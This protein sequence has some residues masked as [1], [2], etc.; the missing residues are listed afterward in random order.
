MRKLLPIFIFVML[1]N[2]ITAQVFK[3]INVQTAGTL[4]TLL[5]AAEKT[6]VTNLTITG[7]IDASDFKFMQNNLTV[8]S[9]LDIS[10][11]TIAEYLGSD[12]PTT[13]FPTPPTY[14]VNEIPNSPFV[15]NSTLSS[16]I[17]PTSIT[18]IGFFAFKNVG[19]LETVTIPQNV[20][21]IYSDAFFGC[22]NLKSVRFLSTTCPSFGTYSSFAFFKTSNPKTAP[23][24]I[25]PIG[26]TNTYR[27][28]SYWLLSDI[29][30]NIYEY[31][32]RLATNAATLINA[33]G[34]VFNG[35]LSFITDSPI[36]SYGFCWNTSGN[37]TISDNKCDIGSIQ[38]TGLY[39]ATVTNLTPATKYY[40]R[41]YATD[42]L[43]TEYGNEVFF[44][45]ASLP[46]SAGTISG[47]QT[48]C[49]GQN[50]VTYTVPNIANATSYIWTLP[51]GATGTSTTNSILV[52]YGKTASS[53][54]ITVKGHN[55]WGDGA[56]STLAITASLLP[57]N[58]GTISG[59]ASV[60]QGQNS[61]NYFVPAIDNATS[62]TWTLPKGATGTSSTN[63]I[64]VNYGLNAE[65]GSI[66]VK[67]HNDCGDG[68]VSTLPII[69]NQLPVITVTDKTVICGGT[70]S[71]N[72]TTNYSGGGILTYQWSPTTGLNDAT[73]AN[74]T[75][76]VTNDITYT[77]TINTPNSCSTSKSLSVTII[78][79]D[80]PEIGMVGVNSDNKNLIAWNKPVSIGIESYNIYR[81][82]NVTNVY[83]KIGTVPYESMSTFV[84]NQSMPDVQSNKYK[85]SI[86]DRHGLESPHSNSHKTIHL[87]INKGMGNTWNLSWE[88]YE[89]F[90]VSTYN[91]YRGTTPSN[92]ALLGSISGSNTQYN[93]LN[94]P[95]G[96]VYYQ[97]EVISPN[98][99]NPTKVISSQ[100]TKA[101]ENGFSNSLISY[102]SSRSNI[103]T[104]VVSGINEFGN[105]NKINI[106]PNPVKN[107][108]RIDFEG[109]S[110]FEILNLTGQVVYIGNLLNNTIV[111]TANLSTGVYLIKFK[112][113]KSFE[114]KKI[115][116]E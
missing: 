113:G 60:C 46:S 21:L 89:G 58:A 101:E 28:S 76:T 37:P 48:V 115:I 25:V 109:G 64:T 55:Q 32:L 73:I 31:K 56:V 108:L 84:D 61:V 102:S 103:A 12:G 24:I 41:A 22:V 47:I 94:V 116:K 4:K 106:Y 96:D 105:N 11:V 82:T 87:A 98:S 15:N 16:I 13:T 5:T 81:E 54:N 110:T 69:V 40:I 53:G 52:N 26:C 112:T 75:A 9:T 79:M 67:G 65:S 43:G 19:K 36:T 29:N 91:I 114:Y 85:L 72:A 20:N 111:Q 86:S 39:N 68:V 92:I 50:S 88:A 45:T 62:Y 49:Q 95:S 97:L 74:P 83:E 107:E 66:T 34:A 17:L 63:N 6:T 44:T 99:V 23:D 104:N 59:N 100:K 30:T 1:A 57:A 27:S 10:N 18:S 33:S 2:L 90:V 80:K 42:G 14:P 77:V 3:T 7:K 93:D 70:V 35:K 51:P 78:P 71:L 8:L 38:T